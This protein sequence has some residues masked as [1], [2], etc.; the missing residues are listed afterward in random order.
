MDELIE[1][2][3]TSCVAC[4]ATTSNRKYEPSLWIGNRNSQKSVSDNGP[5][6]KSFE[7]RKYMKEKGNTHRRI[8]P[9]WPQAN[10]QVERFMGALANSLRKASI[11]NRDWQIA[12]YNFLLSY[13]TTLHSTTN[14][15]P[16]DLM[17]NRIIK[18][19]L[20]DWTNHVDINTEDL[21]TDHIHKSQRMFNEGTPTR[22]KNTFKIGDQ[23]LPKTAPLPHFQ[24]RG[25]DIGEEDENNDEEQPSGSSHTNEPTVIPRPRKQYPK[26]RMRPIEQWRKY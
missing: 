3:I 6:F 1:T 25:A 21:A 2:R 12:C 16:V 4:Q 7:I 13:R 15:A 22:R 10:G 18:T 23:P 14:V 19:T 17:F 9:Y 24:Q 26:R 8:T 20:T 11:E 5:P